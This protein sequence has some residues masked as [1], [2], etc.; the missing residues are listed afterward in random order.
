MATVDVAQVLRST[1]NEDQ[2][3]EEDVDPSCPFVGFE[4]LT[5][6]P[7][8]AELD[9]SWVL[10]V[11]VDQGPSPPQSQRVSRP[12][13]PRGPRD[14]RV[15]AGHKRSRIA[16]EDRSTGFTRPQKRT[17]AQGLV[18][19]KERGTS[20][21]SLAHLLQETDKPNFLYVPSSPRPMLRRPSSPIHLFNRLSLTNHDQ[22]RAQNAPET[23]SRLIPHM[24][25]TEGAIRKESQYL[26][27]P[28]NGQLKL[29]VFLQLLKNWDGV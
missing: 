27:D 1:R 20:F 23:L 26:Y 9:L 5:R 17:R 8:V 10:D 12:R 25:N 14:P 19:S 3:G 22:G 13:D 29:A 18:A 24:L 21:T 16:M 28:I 2:A 4:A 11:G 6:D 7:E 15:A